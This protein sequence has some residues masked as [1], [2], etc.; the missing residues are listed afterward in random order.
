MVTAMQP[1]RLLERILRG[2]VANI[3]FNDLVKLLVALGFAEAGGRG[4][5]RVFTRV[6]VPELINLQEEKGD[7]KPYQVRQIATLVRRYDL[8]LEEA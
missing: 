7:A 4:S 6:D 1:A 3:E 2:D 5:H 8:R